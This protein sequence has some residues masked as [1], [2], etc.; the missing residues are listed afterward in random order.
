MNSKPELTVIGGDSRQ[1][2]AAEHFAKNGFNVKIYGCELENITNKQR[3]C[4]NLS[5][6][7]DSK[8]LVFPLPFS[9]NNK[10]LNNPFSEKNIAVSEILEFIN[11]NH[12][13][14]LGMANSSVI[15]QFRCKTNNVTDYYCEESFMLKNAILTAE[16]IINIITD[17]LPVTINGLKVALTGYGRISY[18]TAKLLKSMGAEVSVT[19]R[20]K[21]QLVKAQL[22]G[23]KT[24]NLSY[25]LDNAENFECIINTVPYPIIDEN[26]IN[27]TRQDCVF[28]E[29]A[30]SPYG[31]DSEACCKAGRTL[32]KA[33]S[34]PGKSSP[35]SAGIIIADTICES[36]KEESYDN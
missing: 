23:Y 22:D 26:I 28:V 14:Y 4:K 30:S 5:E 36:I 10:F 35:K 32:I 33:F 27:K 34:L 31:I 25:I 15:R 2:Y 19:A 20:K 29:A 21:E 17:K 13:I 3:H 18:Y 1:I 7:T 8:Y 12:Y 9:K 11:S 24:F 16:G 6:A